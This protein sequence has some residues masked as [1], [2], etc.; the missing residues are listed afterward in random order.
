MRD[1]V[2]ASARHCTTINNQQIYARLRHSELRKKEK[3]VS[4]LFHVGNIFVFPSSECLS[5]G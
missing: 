5:L 3:N 2:D 1:G 4:R